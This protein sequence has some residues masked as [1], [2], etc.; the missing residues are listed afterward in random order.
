MDIIR[1]FHVRLTGNNDLITTGKSLLK[2]VLDYSVVFI[3]ASLMLGQVLD[4]K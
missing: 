4:Q 2:N 1:G 3:S